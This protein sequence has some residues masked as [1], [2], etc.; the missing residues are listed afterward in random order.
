MYFAAFDAVRASERQVLSA[1]PDAPVVVHP[2][3]TARAFT[4]RRVASE[5]LHRVAH[6]IAPGG[7]LIEPELASGQPTSC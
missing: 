4:L 7:V 2:N 5:Q 6:A 1:R 3:R